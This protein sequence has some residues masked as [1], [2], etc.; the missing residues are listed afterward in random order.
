MAFLLASA[1]FVVSSIL[2]FVVAAPAVRTFRSPAFIIGTAILIGQLI[3]SFGSFW[4]ALLLA[5]STQGAVLRSAAMIWI[6]LATG[7]V[8][9]L[10]LVRP[11]RAAAATCKVALLE[12]LQTTD[13]VLLLVALLFSWLFYRPHLW[14]ESELIYRSHAY[15]DFSIHYP[16]IQGFVLGDNFPPQ[17]PWF[18]GMPLT[19][20]FFSDFLVA[21]YEGL[22]LGLVFSLNAAS[23][24][25]LACM[26]WMVFGAA[27]ELSGSRTVGIIA[28][29]LTV[30]S[31]SLR[32]FYELGLAF[33]TS[34]QEVW[35]SVPRTHPFF[36]SFVARFTAGY[37][38]T[39]YNLF[40]F[41][42]E[43]QMVFAV[44]FVLLAV[45]VTHRREEIGFRWCLG[46]G[47]GAGLFAI[48]HIFA[49]LSV[50]MML[51]CAVIFPKGR[52]EALA[53]LLPL[54]V[55]AAWQ[56][57]P[58]YLLAQTDMFEPEV[59]NFPAFNLHF[60]SM[61]PE[62]DPNL[63]PW[64]PFGALWL[65]TFA[66]GVKPVVALYASALLWR[67]GRSIL[68]SLLLLIIPTFI[69]VNTIQLSPL[70]VYDNHKWLR[71]MN[72]VLD[73]LTAFGFLHLLR[74]S[75]RPWQK[76]LVGLLALVLVGSGLLENATFFRKQTMTAPVAH[77]QSPFIKEVEKK[78]PRDASFLAAN[79][80]ELHMAG[81]NTY[82]PNTKDEVGATD[83][84]TSL[85]INSAP[86]VNVARVIMTAT[87]AERI[88]TVVEGSGITF[89]ERSRDTGDRPAVTVPP[90]AIAVS[91]QNRKGFMIEL[92]D[93]EKLCA[94]F[95]H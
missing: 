28:A 54:C 25:A 24:T 73:I 66:Y 64:S 84:G 69:A 57:A 85:N 20:H 42:A 35:N 12:R 5:P 18:A 68:L 3:A 9:A 15:W 74:L 55:V 95:R 65:Y 63:Y 11:I 71:P 45:V 89:I 23:T 6:V 56:L 10:F 49:T 4:I 76:V 90:E 17:N 27:H 37:N 43:R 21:T 59:R 80:L 13:V 46:L 81:R 94:P 26:L 60:A 33:Q 44:M 72:V 79:T 48:W 41:L 19:Y 16:I 61:E 82:I 22:G 14:E 36:A 87:T 62:Q 47:A 40:Y 77:L 38:G 67:S 2:G 7:L 8:V 50:T 78:T 86:R 70:S 1:F 53:L 51:G 83:M 75:T 92:I 30:T 34:L 93:V 29:I 31:S 91:A 88:C 32:V 39:M 52:R 58:F